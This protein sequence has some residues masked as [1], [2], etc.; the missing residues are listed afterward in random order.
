MVS[1]GVADWTDK[2]IHDSCEVLANSMPQNH[3]FVPPLVSSIL[4]N[5]NPF[6]STF[7]GLTILLGR[8]RVLCLISLNPSAL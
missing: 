5:G 6:I 2:V 8:P 3:H 4:S 1:Q 7:T